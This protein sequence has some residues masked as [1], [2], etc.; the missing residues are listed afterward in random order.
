MRKVLT[1]LIA[2]IISF[3]FLAIPNAMAKSPETNASLVALG[4]SITFGYNLGPNNNH[5]SKLAFPYIIGK[6]E[7]Y[8]VRD[9]GIP[10]WTSTQ[11]L[12][13]LQNDPKFKEAVQ[14]ANVITLDIG[15]NDL[16]QALPTSKTNPI[17]S[18]KV[19]IAAGTMLSN[20]NTI[21]TDVQEQTNAK[22]VVYNIYNAFQV[23]DPLGLHNTSETVLPQINLQIAAIAQA[24]H[25]SLADAYTA[26]EDKEAH[27]VRLNDVHPTVK[28][29]KVLAKLS[30]KILDVNTKEDHK[31][32]KDEKT[33]KANHAGQN[34]ETESLSFSN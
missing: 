8:R 10:G 1:S 32:K 28:G 21:L 30:E 26:F 19:L 6:D 15:N 17:D 2:L 24:H 13:A 16:L 7:G 12:N 23:G 3:G 11:L 9:L 18:S 29:Q 25:A 31:T 20:L 33:E 22:I 14:H 34:K 27:Y 4:D 5:P